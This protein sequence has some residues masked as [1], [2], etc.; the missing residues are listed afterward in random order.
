MQ[1]KTVVHS[2]FNGEKLEEYGWLINNFQTE[3]PQTI[4]APGPA[5]PK[6]DA[7]YEDMNSL[8]EN[9]LI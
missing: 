9:A 2:T 5:V 4:S 1:D 8:E 6:I 3:T 7:A